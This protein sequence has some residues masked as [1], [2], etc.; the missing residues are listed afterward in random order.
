[1]PN[2]DNASKQGLREMANLAT[3]ELREMEERLNSSI[4][5][6]L[7]RLETNL[8]SAFHSWARPMEIKVRDVSGVAFGISETMALIEERL[9]NLE[10][11]KR[12]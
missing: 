5:A 4:D 9:L 10:G 3:K 12:A 1:M 7:E 8:L 6:K 11:R 2:N